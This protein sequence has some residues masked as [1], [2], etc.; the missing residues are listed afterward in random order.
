MQTVKLTTAA[1][2]LCGSLFATACDEGSDDPQ[3]EA[4]AEQAE[5]RSILSVIATEHLEEISFDNG[6]FETHMGLWSDEAFEFVSPFG[7]YTDPDAYEA[8]LTEFY[9]AVESMGGTRHLVINPVVTID[10][11]TAE[12]T[13][14]LQ[15]VNRTDGSFMGSAVMH[16]RLVNT[17]AGWRFVYRSVE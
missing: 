15:V 16:D 12:F 4:T 3:L 7:S 17:D 9:G 2:A 6:D 14:Y 13:G 11:D 8:W 10:G 1:L 5:A